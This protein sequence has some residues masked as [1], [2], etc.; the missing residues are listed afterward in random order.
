MTS[1]LMP[2]EKV[3]PLV[4]P[5]VGG[6]TFDLAE[7]TP[8]NFTMIVFYRGHHCPVCRTYLQELDGMIGDWAEAG[9]SVV[10]VSANDSDTAA[11]SVDEWSLEDL[12]VACGLTVE[13]ASEWGLWVSASFKDGEPERFCEPGLFWVRPDG[14]L[15]L[16][17][18]SNM[19]W[20]ARPDLRMLLSKVPVATEKGYPA[21]GTLRV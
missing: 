15:Y 17:D 10:A 20:G 11:R 5:L 19:P 8:D 21:R 12:P 6:G 13:M 3:P 2:N 16:I 18:I 4:L 1:R 9:F 7:Q 14:R